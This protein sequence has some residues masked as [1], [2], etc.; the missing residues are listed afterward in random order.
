M[1]LVACLVS[2]RG[3][4][5]R[6]DSNPHTHLRRVAF[7]PLNYGDKRGASQ[8]RLA[9]HSLFSLYYIII[10]YNIDI[11]IMMN[12]DEERKV[13]EDKAP[14]R[15]EEIS[16][17]APEFEYHPKDVSWYWMSVI[18]AVVLI[19]LALWQQNLLFILFVAIAWLAVV[20]VANHFPVVW[21]FHADKIGV[22]VQK[23]GSATAP[24]K[25]YPWKDIEGFDVHPGG[26]A[27][28]D[29]I[30]KLRSRFAPFLTLVVHTDDEE[31]IKNFFLAFVPQKEYHPSLAD[32]LAKLVGF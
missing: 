24:R 19:G 6:E 16:W 5:P 9:I 10:L 11:F 13:F 23:A 30:L 32:A 8:E 28:V 15:E 14:E 27:H 18:I 22:R 31:R 1:S 12:H 20:S 21:E 26:E 25:E 3:V 29:L 2:Y 4:R 7:Y 17:Q